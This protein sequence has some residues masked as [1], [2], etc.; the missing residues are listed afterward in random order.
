MKR[1]QIYL[2]ILGLWL[3]LGASSLAQAPPPNYRIEFFTYPNAESYSVRDAN[4]LG[5]VVGWFSSTVNEGTQQSFVIDQNGILGD[6]EAG[7]VYLPRQASW[8]AAWMVG[9]SASGSLKGTPISNP[10]A[11]ASAKA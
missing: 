5:V 3:C 11:P 6:Y 8:V 9:P 1:S 2:V 10:S 7:K 4:N